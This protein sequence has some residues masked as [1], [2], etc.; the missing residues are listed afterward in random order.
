MATAAVETSADVVERNLGLTEIVMR[1]LLENPHVFHSLPDRFELVIL[2]DDDPEIRSY[3]LDLLDRYGSE[4]KPVV[5]ARL[6]IHPDDP[7]RPSAPS[8][9]VPIPVAA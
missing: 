9:F 5:F 1:F 8:I 3:N 7:A 2:P 4:G 6:R